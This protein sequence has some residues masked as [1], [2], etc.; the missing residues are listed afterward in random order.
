VKY[1]GRGGIELDEATLGERESQDIPASTSWRDAPPLR[2]VAGEYGRASRTDG[3]SR[4]IDRTTEKARLAAAIQE[5]AQRVLNAQHPFG[6]GNRIRLSQLEHLATGEFDLFL[7]LL[8]DVV[9]ARASAADNVEILS[10]DGCLM[11]RLEPT[12]DDR[13]ARIRTVD[14]DFSG[15]DQWITIEQIATQDLPEAAV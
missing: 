3:L 13:V 14:G 8:G 2:I 9:S 5:D 4:I 11:V 15:P 7:D 10:G 6:K 12:G 1:T